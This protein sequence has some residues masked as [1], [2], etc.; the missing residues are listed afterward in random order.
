M[1]KLSSWVDYSWITLHLRRDII[2][3]QCVLTFYWTTSGTPKRFGN[4]GHTVA[5]SPG[6]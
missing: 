5:I 4:I 2:Q 3:Q 6:R 1:V